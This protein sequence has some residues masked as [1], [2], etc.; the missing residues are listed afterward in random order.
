MKN[1]SFWLDCIL[2]TAFIY[3]LIGLFYSVST[4]AVFEIFD[5]VGEALGDMQMTDPVFSQL[6]ED[7]LPDTSFI[8]INTGREPRAITAA[9]IDIINQYDP[10]VIALDMFFSYPKTGSQADI[11]GDSILAET[12]KKVENLVMVSKVE[13]TDSLKRLRLSTSMIP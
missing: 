2:G 10:K 12:L 1:R 6:R 3:G 5:P 8:I 11:M 13:Q 9:Q 4:F 7:P